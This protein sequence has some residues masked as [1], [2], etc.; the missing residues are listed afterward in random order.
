MLVDLHCHSSF[1]DGVYAPERVAQGM[2]EAGVRC[3]ALTDHNTIGGQARFRTALTQHGVAC[4]TG[5]EISVYSSEGPLHL[6]AYGFD[7][8]DTSLLSAL[9]IIRNPLGWFA[10]RWFAQARARFSGTLPRQ[11]SAAETDVSDLRFVQ[12]RLDFRDAVDLIHQAG[13][14]AVLAH[15]L[16]RIS[17]DRLTRLLDLMPASGLDGIEAIYQEYPPEMQQM[18]LELAER[19]QLLVTA[20]S[21]YHGPSSHHRTHPGNEMPERLFQR[22][23]EAVQRGTSSACNC[24]I[25]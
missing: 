14:L 6:L 2:A 18:L 13:G 10:R 5:V 9:G 22:F 8:A 25:R 24:S 3:A 15:P 12:G 21:D 20:G 1:S 17:T 16:T 11:P 19:H 4:V 7:T 23:F